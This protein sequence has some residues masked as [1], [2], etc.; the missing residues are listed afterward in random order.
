MSLQTILYI[1]AGTPVWVFALL[2]YLVWQGVG[3][4]RPQVTSIW[5][6]GVVPAIFIVWGLYGL[7]SRPIGLD[8]VAM[9]WLPTAAAGALLGT[10][11]SP[12]R[13]EVDRWHRLVRQPGSALPLVRMLSI[14]IAHYVLNVAM[15]IVPEAK[16]TLMLSDIAVSGIGAGYF[17]GWIATFLYTVRGA[18]EMDLAAAGAQVAAS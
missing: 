2:A 6:V 9:V 11:T 17:I 10:L 4:L 1:V 3:R 16:L 8:Q 13:L 7:F 15:V 14:F 18:P 5:R 12:R